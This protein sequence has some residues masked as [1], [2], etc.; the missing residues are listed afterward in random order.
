MKT[1]IVYY[2]AHHGNTKK[3]IDAIASQGDVTLIDTSKVKNTDLSNYDLIGFASGIYYQ[4]LHESVLQFAK[5]N[6]PVNKKTFII[7]TC[8]VDVKSYPDAIKRIIEEKEG[9]I[10]GVY[11]CPGYDTFGPFKLVGGIK[12]GHPNEAE[13][14]AAVKFFKELQ[15]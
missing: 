1:A 8:G 4:K 9:N 13:I 14:D 12:K 5:N 7:Y 3:L 11:S 15:I 6:L 2:S 10:L